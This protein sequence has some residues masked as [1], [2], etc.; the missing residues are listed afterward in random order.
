[1]TWFDEGRT[2]ASGKIVKL[3]KQGVWTTWHKNGQVA[4]EGE[5]I[6]DA[7]ARDGA[8]TFWTEQGQIESQPGPLAQIAFHQP[9]AR[10]VKG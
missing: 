2:S 7:Q 4:A 9:L 8:W 5:M 1:M 3:K 6:R 10:C